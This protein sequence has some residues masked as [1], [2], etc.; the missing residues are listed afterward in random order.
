MIVA[1]MSAFAAAPTTGSITITNSNDGTVD[2][3]A[4]TFK[5]Y[6]ILNATET[7]TGN[8][9]DGYTASGYAYTIPNAGV[10]ADLASYFNMTQ[11][12]NETTEAFDQRIIEKIGTVTVAAD[13]EAMAKAFLV[14]AKKDAN[15]VPV[16]TLTGGTAK[17]GL[18]FGYYVIE[19]VTTP[20]EKNVSAV[21]L[22]TNNPNVEIKVKASKPGLDKKIDEGTG[23]GATTGRI[24]TKDLVYDNHRIGDTVPYVLE[25]NIPEMTGYTK[26]FYI[27]K[28][29]MSKGLD[30]Q[31]DVVIKRVNSKGVATNLTVNEDYTV[32]VS[33]PSDGTA[34]T[35]IKIVFKDFY[36][37]EKDHKGEKLV[38]TYSAIVTK[39][40]VIGVEGNPNTAKLV[41]SDNPNDD[42]SGEPGDEPQHEGLTSETTE[43][44]VITYVTGLKVKKVDPNGNVL[45]GATFELSGPLNKVV[46]KTSENFVEA[47][48]GE[49]FALKDG[50][51]TKQDP[52]K[53]N[54]EAEEYEANL[55]K[56]VTPDGSVKYK[57]TTSSVDAT[58]ATEGKVTATTTADG[59]AIFDGMG[60]GA[61][62][63]TETAA[64][65]G[66]NKLK[67]PITFTVTYADPT[68]PSEECVW[69]VTGITPANTSVR[70]DK[71]AGEFVIVVENSNGQELP[72]TG[73]MGTTILYVGGSILVLAAVILLIT[74]RR[75][76][77]ED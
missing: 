45:S 42:Y 35:D 25:S 49:Y 5:A 68:A 8:D 51:Y 14:I 69:D 7:F 33:N 20:E 34:D 19:D 11:G 12:A 73:G 27:V 24:D 17:T 75:M 74:K 65:T 15:N 48:D 59:Y 56:Y 36:D 54:K 10:R 64:P 13:I 32:T 22:D 57:K 62:T 38:I 1:S 18:H 53:L 16:E 77:A 28:D 39:D 71:S 30:F 29:T 3:S 46:I 6:R 70:F 44:K 37:K 66:Y 58:A 43:S 41:F 2:A 26:Y 61:F 63:L 40:A 21:M 9:T 50:T 55:A 67:D 31:D 72:S 76:N 60:A 23:E 52:T 47:P 4:R